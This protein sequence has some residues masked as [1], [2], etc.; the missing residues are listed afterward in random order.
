LST[1]KKSRKKAVSL[2]RCECGFEILVVPDLKAMGRAIEDHAAEHAKKE[3]NSAK[4]AFAEARI[5]NLLI[6]LAL[7]KTADL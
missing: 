2:I 6:A 1:K 4:A 7:E 5:Q 3:K